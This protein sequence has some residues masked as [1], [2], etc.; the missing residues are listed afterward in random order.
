MPLTLHTLELKEW[1]WL[2]LF[3]KP[4]CAECTQRGPS[5]NW[6]VCLGRRGSS[7]YWCNACVA[8]WFLPQMTYCLLTR[9]TWHAQMPVTGQ[10]RA[11]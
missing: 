7:Q 10:A 1:H 6:R 9:R 2:P 8:K 4:L 11:P 3:S 5:S